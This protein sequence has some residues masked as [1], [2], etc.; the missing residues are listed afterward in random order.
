M[1]EVE[2]LVTLTQ[3]AEGKAREEAFGELI[4][5]FQAVAHGWAYNVLGD[6]HQAQDVAQEAF[7][8][9]YQKIDQL[10]DPAAFPGWLKRIVLTYCNRITRQHTPYLLP[11]EEEAAPLQ[12]DPAASAEDRDLRE[13][14]NRAVRALPDREREVTE[15]FYITGY[16]QQ[17]IAE[18]LA[19]PLTTVKKRLQY[20]RE[21]LRETMP[22]MNRLPFD[23]LGRGMDFDTE[24]D[25]S[26][27][28]DDDLGD[29]D[30]G[31][32]MLEFLAQRFPELFVLA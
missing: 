2:Q 11:L 32:D 15:L 28:F 27:A 21:H 7:L 16:S 18:Q 24:I 13:Q 3:A 30:L 25:L 23:F 19:L 1:T 9:A 10:R 6:A 31:S 20:A 22:P 17:E 29:D 12:A 4:A 26:G 8:T 5:Q 14:V